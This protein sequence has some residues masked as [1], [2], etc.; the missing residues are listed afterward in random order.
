M[1]RSRGFTL[2]EIVIAI[3]ILS[4]VLGT[5]RGIT[6]SN[7]GGKNWDWRRKDRFVNKLMQVDGKLVA[8]YHEA[9]PEYSDDN[10]LTWK[11]I[12]ND[13]AAASNMLEGVK[14]GK[15]YLSDQD[16]V[17]SRWTGKSLNFFLL[18]DEVSVDFLPANNSLYL[19]VVGRMD[20]C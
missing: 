1:K 10:G 5:A 7:D 13:A 8:L 19:W 11:P 2:V 4:I 3:A 18:N 6:V 17:Y 16:G 12:K 14:S 9:D 15:A 20:G